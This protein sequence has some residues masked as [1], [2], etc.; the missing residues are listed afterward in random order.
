MGQGAT[1]KANGRVK[2][3]AGTLT[4]DDN[5]KLDRGAGTVSRTRSPR[6]PTRSR[7]PSGATEVRTLGR[8]HGR[9]AP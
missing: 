6:P 1:V 4:G 2:E 9:P 8:P 5:G 7:T 3:A